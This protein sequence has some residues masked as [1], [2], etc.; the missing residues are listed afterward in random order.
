MGKSIVSPALAEKVKELNSNST[1]TVEL[2]GIGT[3]TLNKNNKIVEL[4]YTGNAT[5]VPAG[6]S[7]VLGTIPSGYRPIS[8]R[9]I[10]IQMVDNNLPVALYVDTNGN[11]SAYNYGSAISS[12]KAFRIATTW[13]SA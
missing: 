5:N 9:Y 2:T 7:S 12:A 1:T 3:C 8:A 13:V 6:S 11:V 10:L 4:V